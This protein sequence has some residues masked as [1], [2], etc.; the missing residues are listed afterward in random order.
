VQQ[1]HSYL[2]PAPGAS[3]DPQIAA[4]DDLQDYCT[5]R[6]L[7]LLAYSPLL[8][9]AYSRKDRPIPAQ[10]AG[11]DSAAR[12]TALREVAAEQNATTNQV[13]LAWM[14]QSNPVVIPVMAASTEAQMRENLGA[15]AVTLSRDHMQRL[16]QAAA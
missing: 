13:V 1:R 4:N 8:G 2:R 11:A 14:L 16:D 15:L 10:Y 9:G 5:V 12:L 7:T 3:F 6:N